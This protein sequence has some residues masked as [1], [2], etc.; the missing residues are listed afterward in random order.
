MI[1]LR[2][3]DDLGR[4]ERYQAAI[5]GARRITDPA[6]DGSVVIGSEQFQFYAH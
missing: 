4:P 3:S 5:A 2:S 6:L 1:D